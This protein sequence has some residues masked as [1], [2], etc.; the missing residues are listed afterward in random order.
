MKLYGI[1][2]LVIRSNAV[3]FGIFCYFWHQNI[4]TWV[5]F[6]A[7]FLRAVP[8][9]QLLIESLSQVPV[10]VCPRRGKRRKE[11]GGLSGKR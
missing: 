10:G 6:Q 1:Y 11:Q 5:V 7:Q 8:R 2:P 4:K 3:D 9:L